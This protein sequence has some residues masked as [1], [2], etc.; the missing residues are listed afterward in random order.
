MIIVLDLD[1][2][3]IDSARDI[4]ESVSELLES[5]GAAPMPL[6]DVVTMVGDGAPML[7]PA[8]AVSKVRGT[9]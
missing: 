6:P 2:T 3:L 1:G 7:V 5:Y 8:R 9:S 4:A